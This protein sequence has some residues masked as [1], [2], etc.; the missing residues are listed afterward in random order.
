MPFINPPIQQILGQPAA[1]YCPETIFSTAK[2]VVNDHRTSLDP[3][4][5]EQL[6][7]SAARY[8]KNLVGCKLPKLPQLGVEMSSDDLQELEDMIP[9]DGDSDSDAEDDG[10]DFFD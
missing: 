2:F 8:K 9:D 3:H 7:L 10:D 5:A 4:R 6:I 1:S